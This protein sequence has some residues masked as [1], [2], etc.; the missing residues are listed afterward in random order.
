MSIVVRPCRAWRTLPRR[1]A[2]RTRSRRGGPGPPGATASPGTGPTARSRN[3]STRH[4]GHEEQPGHHESAPQLPHTP[5]GIGTCDPDGT[6]LVLHD[7]RREAGR[8][9]LAEKR[10]GRNRSADVCPLRGEIDCC[11]HA[12]ERV[13]PAFQTSRA[14]PARHAAHRQPHFVS[15]CSLGLGQAATTTLVS[16]PFCRATGRPGWTHVYYAA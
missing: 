3:R 4:K 13:Q 7:P 15:P 8:L 9:H 2:T 5:V 11:V 16:V 14:A 10:D 6:E 1:R 12:V